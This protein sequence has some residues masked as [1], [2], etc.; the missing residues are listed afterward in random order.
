MPLITDINVRN[1]YVQQKHYYQAEKF[2]SYCDLQ[3]F[4][5]NY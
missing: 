5:T 2:I 4:T 1:L 3:L